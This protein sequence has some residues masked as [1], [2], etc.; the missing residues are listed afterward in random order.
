[1]FVLPPHRADINECM[2]NKTICKLG[3]I[4]T[5]GS[6]RCEC[7]KGFKSGDSGNCIGKYILVGGEIICGGVNI[8]LD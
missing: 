2:E 4:N 1:M 5:M 3:C 6:Y 7:P 8:F